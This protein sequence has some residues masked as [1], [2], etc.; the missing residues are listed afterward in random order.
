ME[1]LSTLD[2][3]FLEAEDSD[4]HVSLAIG[5]L[6]VIA[7]PMRDIDSIVAGLSDRILPYPVQAFGIAADYDAAPDVDELARGIERAAAHLAAISKV[8]SRST[9]KRTL[10]LHGGSDGAAARA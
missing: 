9:P 1:H 5:A 8:P 6:G 2:T 3:G 10:A 7:G 4:R